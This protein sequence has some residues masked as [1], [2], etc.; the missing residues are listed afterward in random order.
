M[1]KSLTEQDYYLLSEKL[2]EAI[3]QLSKSI[4]QNSKSIE[5]IEHRIFGD[6]HKKIDG[7]VNEFYDF[8]KELSPIV[9][10]QKKYTWLA[11]I[12]WLPIS[13]IF[14]FVGAYLKT[15]ILGHD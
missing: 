5:S 10:Q 6:E 9:E 14:G 15:K 2:S 12:L 11:S 7:L 3:V 13:A 8:K 4:D 1:A